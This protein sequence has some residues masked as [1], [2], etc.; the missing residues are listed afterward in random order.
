[1]KETLRAEGERATVKH[2]LGSRNPGGRKSLRLDLRRCSRS[3]M[4]NEN[5]NIKENSPSRALA[6]IFWKSFPYNLASPNPLLGKHRG[7]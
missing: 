3:E 6:G 2:W 5:I 4:R 7:P 1:M